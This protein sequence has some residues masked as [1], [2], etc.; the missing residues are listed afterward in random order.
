MT[1][2]LK[3]HRQRRG[4]ARRAARGLT[5]L[6]VMVAVAIVGILAAVAMPGYGVHLAKSRRAEAQAYLQ[7]VAVRQ[8][9]FLLDTRAYAALDIVGVTVPTNVATY[10][11]LSLSTT[12]G[13]PPT[14]TLTATPKLKQ[15]EDACGTLS[16]DQ[17]GTKSAARTGCW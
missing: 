15:T 2:G 9:Q 4:A 16:I 11:T 3:V 17:A 14:Y 7:T 12:A 6:E 1:A 5:L 13:P 10:Y 8:Q